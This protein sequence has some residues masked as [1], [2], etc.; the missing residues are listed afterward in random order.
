MPSPI[1]SSI[2]VL[3]STVTGAF[4]PQQRPLSITSF[5]PLS[6]TVPPEEALVLVICVIGAVSTVGIFAGVVI[7]VT[8]P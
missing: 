8:S 4:K 1:L 6:L 7:V 2:I 3:E 5:P